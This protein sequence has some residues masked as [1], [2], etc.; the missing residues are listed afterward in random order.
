MTDM[1]KRSKIREKPLN[2]APGF[3]CPNCK[4]GQIKLSLSEFL[5]HSSVVCPVCGTEFRMDKSA[6]ADLVNQLKD[7]QIATE[8]AR[9]I[10]DGKY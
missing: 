10:A 5:T 3:V 9:A 2:G 8:K 4:K 7:V 6:C 1:N